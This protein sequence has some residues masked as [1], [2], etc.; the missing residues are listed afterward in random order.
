ME[1]GAEVDGSINLP[2]VVPLTV[3]KGGLKSGHAEAKEIGAKIA[4]GE[5]TGLRSHGRTCK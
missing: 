2:N 3:T 5:L 4:S 1:R